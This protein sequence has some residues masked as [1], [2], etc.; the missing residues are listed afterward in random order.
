MKIPFN[1]PL[2][3]GTE[4][5]YL[6]SAIN[7]K[8]FSFG[9]EFTQ[10]CSDFLKNQIGCS[11][12]IMTSSCSGALEMSALICDI[13]PG[14]EVIM[15]SYTYVSTANTFALRG[16]EIVWCDIRKDTKNIDETKIE[17]LITK[18]TKAIV[19]VHYAGIA[20]EIGRIQK[21]CKKYELFL[22]EDTAH[23]I[24]CI[25]QKKPLGSFG[26]LAVISFHE[27]KNIQCGEG[28]T[29]LIN[30]K[31]LLAKADFVSNI[32]TDRTNF[33]K[34]LVNK[35]IWYQ[36]GKNFKLS[37]LQA[38]FL[39][40][41]LQEMKKVN[42]NRKKTWNYYYQ[43]IS[44]FL[45]QGKLP[46]VPSNVSHNAHLFYLILENPQQRKKMIA[47]LKSKGIQAVFHYQPLHQAPF[48][49][50]KYANIHLPVTEKIAETI[51]RLPL[52]YDLKKEEIEY[53][54][55]NIKKSI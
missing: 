46:F 4:I 51:L 44:E 47:F 26:D 54:V 35:W 24:G 48:W 36:L 28:G 25:Y 20:C 23:S 55:K 31:S 9:G 1:K 38:A 16:A 42:R 40:S 18:R 6:N 34:G 8:K 15:P 50:G 53:I 45:P 41:Q 2:V 43:L 32:G 29:L 49:K 19:A 27:S 39:Y 12:A 30:N 52:F 17:K 21:I 7:R 37:E 11:K 22:I 33:N 3:L 10:K 5:L 13:K 14:D